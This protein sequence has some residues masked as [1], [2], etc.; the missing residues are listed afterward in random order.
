MCI[1]DRSTPE[2]VAKIVAANTGQKRSQETCIKIGLAKK[3]T[4]L[5]EE[6]KQARR[7]YRHTE[8]A[9]IK[10]AARKGWKHSDEAKAVMSSVAKKRI[11]APLSDETK[12]K[13]SIAAKRQWERQHA[14]VSL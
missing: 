3:G 6:R 11:R 2:H 8:E 13:L 14:E 10:I 9:K 12:A 1:R 7:D 4:K 5:S